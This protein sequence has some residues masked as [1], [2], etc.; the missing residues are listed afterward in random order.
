MDLELGGK[1]FLVTG[2]SD[3][4]GAAVALRLVREGARVAICAR[5]P[6]RLEAAASVLR[7]AGGDVLAVVADVT[8]A[9]HVDAFV[10]AAAA[11]WGRVDGLVNNAGAAAARPFS[12]LDDAA[13]EADLQLKLV[14]AARA[15]RRARPH[16]RAAGGGAIV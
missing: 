11:R 12:D 5:N 8:R 14:A 2:G 13:W 6:E 15:S 1:V 9:E 7:G 16:L 3:G 10:D 4:L